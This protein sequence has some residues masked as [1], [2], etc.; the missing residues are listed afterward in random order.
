MN[1]KIFM[2][3]GDEIREVEAKPEIFVPLM[4]QGWH[5]TTAPAAETAAAAQKPE[6]SAQEAK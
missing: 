5:Q 3:R 2:K 6:V 1:E 4:A